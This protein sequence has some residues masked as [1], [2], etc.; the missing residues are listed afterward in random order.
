LLH[1]RLRLRSEQFLGTSGDS[2]EQ[3]DS[4]LAAGDSATMLVNTLLVTQ[5]RTTGSKL[6]R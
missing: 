4:V 6:R 1:V 2:F 5:R 3:I